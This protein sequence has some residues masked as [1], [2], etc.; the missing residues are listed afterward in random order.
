MS[1]I[2]SNY[3]QCDEQQFRT[4]SCVHYRIFFVVKLDLFIRALLLDH[5]FAMEKTTCML[6][7]HLVVI[8]YEPADLTVH[9]PPKR[10]RECSFILHELQVP[11]KKF[12][13]PPQKK[14]K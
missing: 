12:L 9:P 3:Q 6:R 1:I 4:L 8:G 13:P 11:E 7:V 10:L 5:I 14:K 2:V